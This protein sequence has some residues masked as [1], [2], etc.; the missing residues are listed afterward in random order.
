MLKIFFN[1]LLKIYN[2]FSLSFRNFKSK[3][4]KNSI[5][6]HMNLLLQF[7]KTFYNPFILF[8]IIFWGFHFRFYFLILYKD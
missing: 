5:R 2:G 8:L 4:S 1:K 7:F 6:V 3:L